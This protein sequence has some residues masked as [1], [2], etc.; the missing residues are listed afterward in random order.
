MTA[1]ATRVSTCGRQVIRQ[2]LLNVCHEARD[3]AKQVTMTAGQ[4][5]FGR[6]FFD[7]TI[8]TLYVPM[9]EQ[10][11]PAAQTEEDP[12]SAWYHQAILV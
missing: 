5:L 10:D 11:S 9:I 6:I 4:F 7:P 3:M 2:T 8:D 12:Y 1:R